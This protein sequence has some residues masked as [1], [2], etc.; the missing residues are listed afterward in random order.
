MK[1]ISTIEFDA[2]LNGR[3]VLIRFTRTLAW[4][5]EHY[6]ADADGNRGMQMLTLD[7]DDYADVH[8]QRYDDW[9]AQ[10]TALAELPAAQQD[11]VRTLVETWMQEH[12]PEAEEECEP[13]YDDEGE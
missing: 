6:G 13:D 7:E 1:Q 10:S 11:A 12:E 2:P 9:D 3:D 4:S 5:W 8:V